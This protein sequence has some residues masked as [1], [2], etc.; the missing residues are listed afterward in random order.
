ME[1]FG[2]DVNR[3]VCGMGWSGVDW[4]G[5]GDVGWGWGDGDVKSGWIAIGVKLGLGLGLGDCV[6]CVLLPEIVANA[7]NSS[8]ST[9]PVSHN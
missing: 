3:M 8:K 5:M 1:C 9:P 2:W 7:T 6:W 4:V